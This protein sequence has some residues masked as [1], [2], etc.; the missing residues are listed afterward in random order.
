MDFQNFY[1]ALQSV[2]NLNEKEQEDE[3]KLEEQQKAAADNAT[4]KFNAKR[5]KIID[6]I[7]PISETSEMVITHAVLEKLAKYGISK[8]NAMKLLK[9]D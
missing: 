9:G 1:Y 8:E 7:K 4:A 6:G 5:D 2:N 3:Q